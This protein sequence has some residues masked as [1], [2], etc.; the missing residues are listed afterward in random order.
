MRMSWAVG[1]FPGKCSQGDRPPERRQLISLIL[2][3][4]ERVVDCDTGRVFG[5]ESRQSVIIVTAKVL[6]L[7]CLPLPGQR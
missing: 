3:A 6:A 7:T 4:G 2:R 5:R 1:A